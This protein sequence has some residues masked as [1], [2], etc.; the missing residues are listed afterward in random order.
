M[1]YVAVVSLKERAG[2]QPVTYVHP[3]AAEDPDMA[4]AVQVA[5]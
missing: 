1:L 4:V 3:E 2:G 5:R